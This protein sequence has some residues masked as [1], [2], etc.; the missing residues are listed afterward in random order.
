MTGSRESVAAA[1][2]Q[3]I[4]SGE[5]KTLCGSRREG[6]AKRTTPPATGIT[7]RSFLENNGPGAAVRVKNWDENRGGVVVQW[8]AWRKD[9]APHGKKGCLRP[10]RKRMRRAIGGM[11][12]SWSAKTRTTSRTRIALVK[13]PPRSIVAKNQLLRRARGFSGASV[14]DVGAICPEVRK[15]QEQRR[16]LA[17]W[18]G[19]DI[20]K[21]CGPRNRNNRHPSLEPYSLPP[22]YYRIH[23]VVLVVEISINVPQSSHSYASPH[24]VSGCFRT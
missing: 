15:Y 18:A 2:A 16:K 4:R 14:H 13:T 9:E 11:R 5:A 22:A 6:V 23:N 7:Q 21:K 10:G 20:I 3:G 12:T 8:E 24:N 1:S 17:A 19:I